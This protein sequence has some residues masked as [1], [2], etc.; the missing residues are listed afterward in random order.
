MNWRL[1]VILV[2]FFTLFYS[3]LYA[4]D[5]TVKWD[6]A[7]GATSYEIEMQDTTQ[8]DPVWVQVKAVA[9][10]TET[11]LEGIPENGLM[12]FRVIS[13][14]ANGKTV[15][16][17]AGAWYDKTKQIPSKTQGFGIAE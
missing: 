6:A 10:V 15:N 11:L 14:N 16:A 7:N 4:A 5:I 1:A 17:N 9:D 2:L 13:V 3:T 8:P 12:L